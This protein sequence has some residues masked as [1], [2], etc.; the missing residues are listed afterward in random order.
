MIK[1]LKRV[2]AALAVLVLVLVGLLVWRAQRTEHPVG[3]EL[4]RA[5]DAR[6]RAF[7]IAIWYPT[8]DTPRP[9]TLLGL[10]LMSVAPEG[11]IDG[12]GLP[13]VVI[14]HGNLG[15]LVSHADLAMALADA[16]YVVA[17]PMHTGD[18]FQDGSGVAR[19]G[20]WSGRNR[21]LQ[22]TIDH[23]LTRWR[24]HDRIDA[25]RIGAFGFSA[26]GFTVL[27]AIGARADLA[28]VQ[29]H[30]AQAREFACDVLRQSGS[31]LVDGRLAPEDG[32]FF[33]DR[34]IRAAV[35]AAPGLG[36]TFADGLD[37]VQVPVQLWAGGRDTTVPDAT[38][39]AI[40]RDGLGTRVESHIEPGAGHMSFLA[41]C[42][43]FGPPPLCR[44]EGDFDREAFH[45]TMNAEVRR[46]FDTTLRR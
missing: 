28:R 29:T 1:W 15:G 3:F 24:G 9:T 21:Q 6:G 27:T 20:F 2:L 39:T 46:F 45:R 10:S 31:A 23:L 36:F 12:Q 43:L 7:P 5:E 30:C 16:G 13:L 37:A 40:V 18:N 35:V 17:A 44:D 14:S 41:P 19:P 26:G 4:V 25:A 32:D 11:A 42:R 34:R 38:N 8:R 33:V 22:A